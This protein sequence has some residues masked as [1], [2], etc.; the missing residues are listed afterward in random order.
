MRII[1]DISYSTIQNIAGFVLSF[2]T[3]MLLARILGAEEFGKY[4]FTIWM[5]GF[6][7]TIIMLGLP[8]TLTKYISQLYPAQKQ[9][10]QGF[11]YSL[12]KQYIILFCLVSILFYL[13]Y[14][15]KIPINYF[16]VLIIIAGFIFN[17]FITSIISGLRN[18]KVLMYSSLVSHIIFLVLIIV[19]LRKYAN[20]NT[21][22][23]IY[24]IFLLTGF[25]INI[26]YEKRWKEIVIKTDNYTQ[27]ELSDISKYYRYV[28]FALILDYVVWQNSEIFFL[29]IY[30]PVK[31]I[32][33]YTIAYSLAFLPQRLLVSSIS[34]VMLPFMSNIYGKND[35]ESLNKS[36][37]IFTKYISFI[38]IP[39]YLILFFLADKVIQLLYGRD[40]LF[41]V[42]SVRIILCSA[43]F[44]SIATVGS[45]YVHTIEKVDIIVKIGFFVALLNI[46]LNI[47]LIPKYHSIGAAIGNSLAQIVA[48]LVGT[49]YLIYSFKLKF[50]LGSILKY[51]IYS[52]IGC[53]ITNFLI[54]SQFQSVMYIAIY[55]LVCS[56]VY[57]G[58]IFLDPFE[59]NEFKKMLLKM[60]EKI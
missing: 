47:I 31:E 59:I 27:K 1:K 18:F 33:F 44:G 15:N 48:C 51:F 10:I 8:A 22:I 7:S 42:Y 50:P 45:N 19:F 36:Y 11:I 56:L 29:R 21:A 5:I 43:L 20:C 55:S 6:F 25:L 32:S 57:I 28:S 13:I 4:S 54:L 23:L 2:I 40:Y 39:I 9:R 37:T 52:F 14:R 26:F 30:S 58:F 16:F 17:N 38:F 24:T 53:Y 12:I 35:W 34:K 41:C 46:V 3:S 60:K 49:F